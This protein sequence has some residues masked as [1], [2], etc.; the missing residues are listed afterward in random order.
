MLE[1]RPVSRVDE[2]P[3]LDSDALAF[4]IARETRRTVVDLIRKEKPTT[5]LGVLLAHQAEGVTIEVI[6][7]N[8]QNS[9]GLINWNLKKLEMEDLC[10]RV[11]IEGDVR[12]LPTAAYTE[13][14]E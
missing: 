5:I 6:A 10:V 4:D 9:I 1:T 8:L 3:P 13:R 2:L 14:N 11:K 7:R 12:F